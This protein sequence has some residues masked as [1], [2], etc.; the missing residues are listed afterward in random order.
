MTRRP[1]FVGHRISADR[2]RVTLLRGIPVSDRVQS[3]AECSTLLSLEQ[4]VIAGDFLVG[5]KCRHAIDELAGVVAGRCGLRGTRL[6]REAL[7][8]VAVGSESPR[9][10]RLR[11]QLLREGFRLPLLNCEIHDEQDRFV[12]RPDIIFGREHVVVEYDGDQHR[13]DRKTYRDD[14]RR[15]EALADAGWHALYLSDDD[16]TGEHWAAFV[17]RLRRA[18]SR[19][20]AGARTR[21]APGPG[22]A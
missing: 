17:G 2:A 15:R 13:T 6:L 1:G 7:S 10:T 12:A 22:P 11:L 8:L 5:K 3:W 9:E 16:L 21:V 18:L 4:L 19:G 20:E 14:K